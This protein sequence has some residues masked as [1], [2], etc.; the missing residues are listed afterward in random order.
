MEGFQREYCDFL[1][2][3]KIISL[4]CALDSIGEKFAGRMHEALW[5]A[6]N[7]AVIFAL[8]KNVDEIN[9][10]MKPI[11]DAL[12]PSEPMTYCLGEILKGKLDGF[13]AA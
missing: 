13:S 8:S 9:R 3:E 10:V 12:R 6:R 7:T 11:I 1:R 2:L 4:E 5:D